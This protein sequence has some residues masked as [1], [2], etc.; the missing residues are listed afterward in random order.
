MILLA[1]KSLE[2]DLTQ[3]WMKGIKAVLSPLIMTI[4]VGL[5]G[6]VLKN[7]SESRKPFHG[8]S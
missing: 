2:A 4:L 8:T 5:A 1:G 7:I 3:F 6:G